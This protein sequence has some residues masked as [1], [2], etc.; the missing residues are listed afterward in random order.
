MK[1]D[2]SSLENRL[3]LHLIRNQ[4]NIRETANRSKLLWIPRLKSTRA[5]GMKGCLKEKLKT[6]EISSKKER[7][8]AREE[9]RGMK[10]RGRKGEGEKKNLSICS[11]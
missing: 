9:G 10:K 1:E 8:R 5:S 3:T 7:K 11:F 4:C 2:T 6:M